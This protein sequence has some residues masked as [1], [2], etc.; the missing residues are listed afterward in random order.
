M[1]S[2]RLP[3][4]LLPPGLTEGTRGLV[5]AVATVVR[6]VTLLV[7]WD[8]LPIATPE[9]LSRTAWG[10]DAPTLS[11]GSAAPAEGGPQGGR[12]SPTPHSLHSSSSLLSPQSLMLSHTQKRGLQNL[13]LHVNW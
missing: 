4:F 1:C 2:R 6:P 5:G 7:L 10:W 13:F 12:S 9:G 11:S 8:A 3:S